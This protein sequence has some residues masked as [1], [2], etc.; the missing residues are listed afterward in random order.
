MENLRIVMGLRHNSQ[1]LVP[2]PMVA[3]D[4]R[5]DGSG[6]AGPP[7]GRGAGQGRVDV[8]AGIVRSNPPGMELAHCLLCSVFPAGVV[9]SKLFPAHAFEG[10]VV[11]VFKLP[12]L[13]H[14]LPPGRRLLI[15]LFGKVA[16]EPDALVIEL[17]P[18]RD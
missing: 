7:E 9:C 10:A 14:V 12:R 13:N 11:D 18:D 17:T 16:Q 3:R 5:V 2:V 8:G 4:R 15:V 6:W 1:G